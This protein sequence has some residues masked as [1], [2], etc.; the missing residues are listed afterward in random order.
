MNAAL[1]ALDEVKRAQPMHLR[2]PG[3]R[4]GIPGSAPIWRNYMTFSMPNWSVKFFIDA[5]LMKK[6]VMSRLD[7]RNLVGAQAAEPDRDVTALQSSSVRLPPNPKVVLYTSSGSEKPYKLLDETARWGFSPAA[8]IVETGTPLPSLS[9]RLMGKLR[10]DGAAALVRSLLRKV[11][12][13][14]GSGSTGETT[15]LTPQQVCTQRGIPMWTVQSVNSP[16]AM[17]IIAGLEPDLAVLAGAG[18]LRK[19]L[20]DIPKYATLNAHMG[21]LPFYRGMNVTEWAALNG[22]RVGCTVHQVDTGIDTGA[23]IATR[24]VSSE[25]AGSIDELRDL[26]DGAQIRLLADVLGWCLTNH[27][28]PVVRTQTVEEGLQFFRMHDELKRI[29]EHSLRSSKALQA[30]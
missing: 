12:R 14:A 2:H 7:T 21:L 27:A 30:V 18:I 6:E 4:G 24:S 25:A 1:K 3:L 23:I 26:V 10:D 15:A 29:L 8:M 28:M 20:V 11:R 9:A 22:N 5:L 16:E 19:A 13:G 17:R